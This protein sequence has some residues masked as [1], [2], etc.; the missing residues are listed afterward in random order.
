VI[1]MPEC[2][3]TLSDVV[4]HGYVQPRDTEKIVS[5][6]IDVC[7]CLQDIHTAGLI[8]GDVKPLNIITR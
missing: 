8:H 1:V 3:R 4:L 2:G 5:I 6:M 7:R